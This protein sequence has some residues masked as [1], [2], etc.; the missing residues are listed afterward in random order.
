[1]RPFFPC[2]GGPAM[3][4]KTISERVLYSISFNRP[5][6][7]SFLQPVKL[8]PTPVHAGGLFLSAT[9]FATQL[10]NARREG[11]VTDHIKRR[12][13]PNLFSHNGTNAHGWG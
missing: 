3:T 10:P 8:M 4:C 2:M 12:G 5:A 7:G 1:M 9:E 6:N 13:N 11:E